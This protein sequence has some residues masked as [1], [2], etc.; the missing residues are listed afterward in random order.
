MPQAFHFQECAWIIFHGDSVSRISSSGVS[1]RATYDTKTSNLTSFAWVVD[2]R[3]LSSVP[4]CQAVNGVCFDMLQSRFECWRACL[5]MNRDK[6]DL[7]LDPS[8]RISQCGS[9]IAT[10]DISSILADERWPVSDS[11]PRFHHFE[12][13]RVPGQSA[14]RVSIREEMA[15]SQWKTIAW[16]TSTVMPCGYRMQGDIS[17]GPEDIDMVNVGDVGNAQAGSTHDMNTS[18]SGT[19]QTSNHGRFQLNKSRFTRGI[20]GVSAMIGSSPRMDLYGVLV[21]IFRHLLTLASW[22]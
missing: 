4:G 16:C 17:S 6:A 19:K 3:Q 5:W 9:Q 11:E 10:G 15:S 21:Y 2:S 13:W 12:P 22:A 14:G 8:S 20:I 7:I 1:L 18:T